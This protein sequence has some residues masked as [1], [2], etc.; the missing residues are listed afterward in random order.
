MTNLLLR[1]KGSRYKHQIEKHTSAHLQACMGNEF[2][3]FEVESVLSDVQRRMH[4]DKLKW[5]GKSNLS[6]QS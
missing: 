5:Y 3:S 2:P 1:E 4:H 6:T